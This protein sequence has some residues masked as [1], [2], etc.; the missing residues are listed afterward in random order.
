MPRPTKR[1]DK[2][3][4][5]EGARSQSTAPVAVATELEARLETITQENARALAA[6]Q[7]MKQLIAGSPGQQ[8]LPALGPRRDDMITVLEAMRAQ[9][10]EPKPLGWID[11]AP[12]GSPRHT[13]DGRGSA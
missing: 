3:R 6:L 1:A 12:R 7:D 13:G 9:F 8:K 2:S 10:G 5:N 4:R 11:T